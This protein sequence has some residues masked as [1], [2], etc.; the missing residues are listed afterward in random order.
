M[1]CGSASLSQSM[2]TPPPP[3]P[4]SMPSPAP[5]ATRGWSR[6]RRRA[7]GGGAR[8]AR[9][10]AAP[11]APPPPPRV[12]CAPQLGHCGAPPH[13]DRRGSAAGAKPRR[14]R[15]WED[16]V[17]VPTEH[18]ATLAARLEEHGLPRDL[19]GTPPPAPRLKPRGT[20][21][22]PDYAADARL[23][24]R[25]R[26]TISGAPATRFPLPLAPGGT[27]PAPRGPH[28]ARRCGG[29]RCGARFPSRG[30]GGARRAWV[31]AAAPDDSV[32]VP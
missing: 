12:T 2:E 26:D 8:R 20:E 27:L 16:G 1:L 3:R 25:M 18:E 32:R 24:A 23:L 21:E 15:A 11:R 10:A 7:G 31:V 9:P 6:R 17:P 30:G 14:A 5:N 28:V 19:C 29:V 22:P 13:R 4:P